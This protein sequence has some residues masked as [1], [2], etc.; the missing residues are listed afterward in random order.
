MTAVAWP[1]RHWTVSDV[2]TR[3]VHVASLATPFKLLVRLI[4]ENRISAVPVVDQAGVPVG[5]V[6]EADLL[7]KARR[8]EMTQPNLLHLRRS[9]RDRAKAE[10]LVAADLMTS[11]PITART[12][13]TLAQAART[14]QEGSVRRLV[15]VDDRG[16][17]A[18]VVTRADLLQVFLR[19]DEEIRDQITDVII[20]SFMFELD[21]P[22]EVE[23]LYNVVTVTGKVDRRTDVELL[24][25]Q[26]NEV[27]GVVDVV[28]RLTYSWDD[29]GPV[30]VSPGSRPAF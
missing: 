6:S 14:M 8:S 29:T 5:V 10:G 2:M 7:L 27:D 28:N 18:G 24:I 16:R 20:P 4:E 11:P 25:R 3:R 15:V 12:D 21:Q 22:I 30:P 26:I 9:R 17:I 19:T 23:V 1:T 13:A